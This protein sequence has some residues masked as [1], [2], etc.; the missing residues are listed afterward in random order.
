MSEKPECKT[1]LGRSVGRWKDNI[2]V[3][4]NKIG[5]DLWIGFI[6]PRIETG[7]ELLL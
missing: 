6:W 3:D 5:C 7:G 1:P 2:K 4:L